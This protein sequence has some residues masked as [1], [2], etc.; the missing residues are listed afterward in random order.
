MLP[1]FLCRQAITACGISCCQKIIIIFIK[2]FIYL[3][4]RVPPIY[5]YPYIYR[6]TTNITMIF[7][8]CRACYSTCVWN[9][10]GISFTKIMF[11]L[12]S[13]NFYKYLVN[14]K[15]VGDGSILKT[16]KVMCSWE[17]AGMYK[18][19][20]TWMIPLYE[21]EKNHYNTNISWKLRA[22]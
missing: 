4:L 1:D 2:P 19:Y 17:H 15:A 16:V 8:S 10:L 12:L 9:R 13:H 3:N 22:G 11:F 20:I 18:K 7:D 14:Y 6:Y 21:Q 5:L